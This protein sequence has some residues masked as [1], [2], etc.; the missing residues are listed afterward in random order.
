MQEEP[1]SIRRLVE[2]LTGEALK[3]FLRNLRH[4]VEVQ[5]RIARGELKAEQVN[6]AYLRYA[7]REGRSYRD[8]VGQ[9]TARYYREL[10]AV[11][12]KYSERFY[13]QLLAAAPDAPVEAAPEDGEQVSLEL[14]GLPGHELVR[15]FALENP[16]DGEASVAFELGECTGPDGVPFTAPL[17][18]QPARL[19]IPPRGRADVTLRLALLPSLFTPGNVYTMRVGVRGPQKLA[20]DLVIWAE[21]EMQTPAAPQPAEQERPPD[22]APRRYAVRCPGCG[23]TFTRSTPRLQLNRH[24]APDG[25]DCPV[26][27]GEPAAP[28]SGAGVVTALAGKKRGSRP[29]RRVRR[30]AASG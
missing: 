4:H 22:E 18:V 16:D 28:D 3:Q 14:H 26:R 21:E 24:K 13:E 20:V 9:L 12:G 17:A 5:R 30:D 15:R 23:R 25:T 2:T 11:G 1:E 7:L 10:V 19:T 6:G 8:E 29:R 27:R